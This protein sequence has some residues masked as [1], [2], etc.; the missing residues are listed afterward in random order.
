V[1]IAGREVPKRPDW[2]GPTATRAWDAMLAD[3][4][5]GR[6]L[7]RA[8]SGVLAGAAQLFARAVDAGA[9]IDKHGLTVSVTRTGRDGA[10]WEQPLPHP[11]LA[12]ERAAWREFRMLAEQLGLSPVAR[13]RLGQAGVRHQPSDVDDMPAVP[14]RLADY[15]GA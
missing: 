13:A 5:E 6:V 7:D 9:D 2:L 12:A 15:R 14:V 8:D 3:L 11:L 4:T 1:L 10:S